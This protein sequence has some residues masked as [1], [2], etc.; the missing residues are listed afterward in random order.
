MNHRSLD[1]VGPSSSLPIL[2]FDVVF[3]EVCENMFKQENEALFNQICKF[4]NAWTNHLLWVKFMLKRIRFN[5]KCWKC[6]VFMLVVDVGTFY[7]NKSL[8]HA[9]NWLE[10][11]T[12]TTPLSSTDYKLNLGEKEKIFPI[13]LVHHLLVHG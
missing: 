2:L 5:A 1:K 13:F 8:M 10:Y 3:D 11:T 6:K 4:Q 9:R 12:L 7:F